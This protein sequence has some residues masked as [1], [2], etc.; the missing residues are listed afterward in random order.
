M[1]P[2]AL[3]LCS[4]VPRE[5]GVLR[6]HC[7]RLEQNHYHNE[8]GELVFSQIVGWDQR[9]VFFWRL[10]KD[11]E[12]IPERTQSGW[13]LRWNDRGSLREV[14][15]RSYAESWTQWDIETADRELCPRRGPAAVEG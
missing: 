14:H 1:L 2:L 10:N 3:L 7:E 4:I 11:S 9:H 5:D 6:D 8:N 15:A 13:V 12:L